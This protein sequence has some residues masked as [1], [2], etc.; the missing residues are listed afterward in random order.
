MELLLKNATIVRT[1]SRKNSSKKD[2][3]IKNGIIEKI[4]SSLSYKNA[5]I[6]ESPDLHVSPGWLDIGTQ[7]GEPGFEQRETLQTVAKCAAK[8]GFTAIACFPNTNPVMD[9][10]AAV[11]FI[12]SSTARMAV[13]FLPIG[14]L[15]TNT[16]GTEITDMMDLNKAGVVAFSDGAKS[17]QNSGVL[18]RALQYVKAFKGCIIHRSIDQK[19]C[20]GGQVHEGLS[21]VHLGMKGIPAIA[22]SSSIQKDIA[23]NTYAESKL[24]LHLISSASSCEVIKESKKSKGQ[25]YTTVSYLNLLEN[26]AVLE[27]FDSNFKV[28]PPLRAEQDQK[29][30]IKG[31]KDNTIDAI[32]TNHVPLEEE[33]KKMEFSYA[34][35]GA[36]GLQT[37]FP[38]LCEALSEKIGVVPLIDKLSNGPRKILGLPEIKI[39]EGEKAELSLFDPSIQWEFNAKSNLSKSKNSPYLGRTFSCKVLGIING[40]SVSL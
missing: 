17:L 39:A 34:D 27:N 14:A 12:K 5:R 29:A 24:V 10:K 25:L 26:E 22:E 32:C 21:S 40:R 23:L 18:L 33:K 7:I 31:I 11:H 35:F 30:L 9:N 37:A 8:G 4:G 2:I 38:A 6:V 15:S 3:F 16:K 20:D 13:D 36:I 19:I 1:G 28:N